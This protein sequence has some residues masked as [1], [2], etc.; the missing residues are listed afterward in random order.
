MG[1]L[2]VVDAL[3]EIAHIFNA[4]L[5]VVSI[6]SWGERRKTYLQDGKLV[7]LLPYACGNHILQDPKLLVHLGPSP[8]LNQAMGRLARN[9]TPRRRGPTRL[10]SLPTCGGGRRR[11][12]CRCRGRGPQLVLR[13]FRLHLDDLA[14]TRWRRGKRVVILGDDGTLGRTGTLS[15]RRSG[16]GGSDWRG[17]GGWSVGG[18]GCGG[19]SRRDVGRDAAPATYGC[20]RQSKA[21]VELGGV[22]A[23]LA[24]DVGRRRGRGG[25]AGSRHDGAWAC[26]C[27]HRSGGSTSTGSTKHCLEGRRRGHGGSGQDV[28]AA[29][30]VSRAISCDMRTI[31]LS[32]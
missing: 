18:V 4:G 2:E 7:H 15:R 9:L 23:A 25:E 3:L 14:R 32:R 16:L 20:G 27:A 31:T 30:M 12:R 22:H 10:L 5:T 6:P 29:I 1:D 26:L 24:R 28:E 11:F 19:C 8:P 21:T 13:L 17:R